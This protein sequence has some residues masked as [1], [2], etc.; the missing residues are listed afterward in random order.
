M[1]VVDVSTSAV[2]VVN[3]NPKRTSLAISNN[4]NTAIIYWAKD[5]A[6]TTSTGFPI[7]PQTTVIFAR[8]TGDDPTIARYAISDTV[9]KS[10]RVEEE[11]A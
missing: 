1:G 9:S 7:Y 11:F 6:V 5:K 2:Q 4:D 10:V 8:Y 3:H